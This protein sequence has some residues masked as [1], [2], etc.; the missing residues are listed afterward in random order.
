[1][2]FEYI[3]EDGHVF[4]YE[5]TLAYITWKI[6]NLKTQQYSSEEI[7]NFDDSEIWL[8]YVKKLINK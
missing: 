8:Y 6:Q 3:L 5:E 7:I 1:M 2:D 4:S